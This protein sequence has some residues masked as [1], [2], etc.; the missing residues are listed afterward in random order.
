MFTAFS[1]GVYG[2]VS[3]SIDINTLTLII[4]AAGAAGV[5]AMKTIKGEVCTECQYKSFA[6]GNF[7]EY[8]QFKLNGDTDE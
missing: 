1:I 7:R 6:Q 4:S 5:L 3:G 8:Q 2:V